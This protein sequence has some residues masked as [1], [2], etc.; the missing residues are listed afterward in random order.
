MVYEVDKTRSLA[1]F[2]RM[3]G[4]GRPRSF[5]DTLVRLTYACT[6]VPLVS[7]VVEPGVVG[8]LSL[9]EY[10]FAVMGGSTHL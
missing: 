1:A 10:G 3:W 4:H 5:E 7:Y 9:I 6:Q 8:N 2:C